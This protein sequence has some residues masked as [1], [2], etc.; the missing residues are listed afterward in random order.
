[1]TKKK[2]LEHCREYASKTRSLVGLSQQSGEESYNV[3]FKNG[4]AAGFDRCL[5]LLNPKW[6]KE[7]AEAYLEGVYSCQPKQKQERE[8]DKIIR[9]KPRPKNR[10]QKKT[11]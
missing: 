8:N 1:M 7:I 10:E 4:F 9:R 2:L 3:G 6:D 5:H 11:D